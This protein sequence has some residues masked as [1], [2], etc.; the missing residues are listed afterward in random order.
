MT[1]TDSSLQQ[2]P[3]GS[4][5]N[6]WRLAPYS[7]WAFQNLRELIPSALLSANKT[8]SP[9][10]QNHSDIPGALKFAC[11]G[12]AD[13]DTVLTESETDCMV[14]LHRGKK[15]WQWSAAHCDVARPHVVFSISKSITAMMTGIL[16]GQGLID[17][18]KPVVYYL[19]GT[20]NSAYEDCSVQQ[21]LD[22]TVAL[23]FEESYLDATGD[24]RRYR[25]A[26]GWNPVDQNNPGPSLE[27]FLYGLG[28]ADYAHGEIFNYKSPNSDLLGLLLERAA[29]V[30]FADLLSSLIWQPMGA[31]TDGYVTVDREMLARGAG[32]I[33][34]TVDDLARFG[35]LILDG[36]TANNQSVIPESWI[37]DTLTQ[38][39]RDAWVKGD[40]AYLLP[41]GC[42]RNKWYQIG[43]RQQCYMA[44]GI[45]GQWL[46]IDP[47][48]SVVIAKLS[49]QPEPVDDDLDLKLLEIFAELS[50]SFDQ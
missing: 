20:S 30:P 24:Y 45:H 41:N 35:Q 3:D 48:P 1:N 23:A 26:S 32:G 11:A 38:G 43:N 33:C 8:A 47:G 5:L 16:V 46:Y 50:H 21:L 10:E 13:L 12:G 40:Y 14:I 29:G 44:L 27:T 2:R 34:V 7:Q 17:V 19:P 18:K 22:M 4:S 9:L 37:R 49:S 31:E 36:G 6:N 15:V 39:D 28:K 42:Y 25:D